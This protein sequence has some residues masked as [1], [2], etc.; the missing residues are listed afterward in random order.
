MF[1]CFCYNKT[2]D[3]DE[4]FPAVSM[5]NP[6]DK[7]TWLSYSS[8]SPAPKTAIKKGANN[9]KSNKNA[10]ANNKKSRFVKGGRKSE[11]E[12]EEVYEVVGEFCPIR[13][14][15]ADLVYAV[16]SCARLF[17]FVFFSFLF[18]CDFY[19]SVFV[20][21]VQFRPYFRFVSFCLHLLL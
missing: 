15:R 18:L 20:L 21:Y 12:E 14:H 7:V 6:G 11:E 3:G 4:L 19:F 5:C 10:A 1:C 9:S 16:S 2:D 8:T 13:F 17:P